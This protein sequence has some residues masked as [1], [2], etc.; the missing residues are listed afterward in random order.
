MNGKLVLQ[1]LMEARKS[2]C[3]NCFGLMVLGGWQLANFAFTSKPGNDTQ[4]EIA[5]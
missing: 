4:I 1:C 5:R 2:C 3:R